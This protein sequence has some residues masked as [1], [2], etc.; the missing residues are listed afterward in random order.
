LAEITDARRRV[1]EL[2]Q[3]LSRRNAVT[4]R[5]LNGTELPGRGLLSVDVL[6]A[7]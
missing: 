7:T 5:L 4:I 3:E 6:G 1:Q 2:T